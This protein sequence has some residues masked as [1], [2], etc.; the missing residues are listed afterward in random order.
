MQVS[1]VDE[2]E[3]HECYICMQNELPLVRPCTCNAYVHKECFAKA[4]KSQEMMICTIC[5]KPLQIKVD[6]YVRVFSCNITMFI[7]TVLAGSFFLSFFA[8]LI[9][10]R[11]YYNFLFEILSV[12]AVMLL[13][14]WIML[15]R[16]FCIRS[17]R[18]CWSKLLPVPHRQRI[19]LQDGTEIFLQGTENQQHFLSC[20][21]DDIL[22]QCGYLN[23]VRGC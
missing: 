2:S 18:C 4:L 3:E 6:S 1:P 7:A 14:A 10:V 13:C 23:S 15:W 20:T 22:F 11:E 16:L 8:G 5:K 12:P 9:Y 19:T 21:A 17:Q